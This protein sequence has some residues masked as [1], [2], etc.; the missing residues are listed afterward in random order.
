[1]NGL[2][3]TQSGGKEA[4]GLEYVRERVARLMFVLEGSVL[5]Y[6]DWGSQVYSILHEPSDDTTADDITNELDFL[7]SSREDTLELDSVE[8]SLVEMG[9]GNEGLVVNANVFLPQD[10]EVTELQFFQILEV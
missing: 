5:G 2:V 8:V 7:F 10:E 3:L 9:N 4:Y 6:P 1:M